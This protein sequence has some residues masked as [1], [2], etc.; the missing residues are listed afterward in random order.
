[1]LYIVT[2]T[3]R[4]PEGWEDDA[5]FK[6]SRTAVATLEEGR[7]WITERFNHRT[8]VIATCRE[9][10]QAIAPDGTVIEVRPITA[11]ALLDLCADPNEIDSA[12]C[13]LDGAEYDDAIAAAFNTFNAK[14]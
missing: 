14:S 6:P 13:H 12:T 5:D 7:A 8:A 11:L 9:I 4:E 10:D 2:T 1:M 3:P